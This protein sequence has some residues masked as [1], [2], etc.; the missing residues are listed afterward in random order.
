MLSRSVSLTPHIPVW[1]LP[2]LA[3]VILREHFHESRFHCW[4]LL[5]HFLNCNTVCT[6]IGLCILSLTG[7]FFQTEIHTPDWGTSICMQ[8]RTFPVSS[9]LCNQ[10]Q[11]ILKKRFPFLRVEQ[12]RVEKSWT[13]QEKYSWICCYPEEHNITSS[14]SLLLALMKLNVVSAICCV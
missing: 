4:T 12:K 3:C 14:L 5:N 10:F 9:L 7:M 2:G 6:D 11:A 8:E 13:E 1:C